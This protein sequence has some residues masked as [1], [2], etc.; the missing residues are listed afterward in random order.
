MART[1]FS[2]E[3]NAGVRFSGWED[4]GTLVGVM[5]VGVPAFLLP[6]YLMTHVTIAAR[7]RTER[8]DRAGSGS[9]APADAA[10][11]GRF[12]LGSGVC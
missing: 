7:L 12:R 8:L 10:R 4:S 3:I 6:L 5:G 2:A 9:P 11:H 1:E